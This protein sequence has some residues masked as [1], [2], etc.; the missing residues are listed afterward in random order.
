MAT[1][2]Q[3]LRITFAHRDGQISL[4]GVE[5][6]A[7]IPPASIGDP[8][9]R[10]QTGY[11]LEVRDASGRVL[12]HR[13]LHD[14]VR[15]DVEAFSPDAGP[16]ISRVPLREPAGRFTVLVPDL[17]DAQTFA[18]NGPAHPDRPDEPAQELLRIAVD[19][20]RRAKPPSGPPISTRP[21]G[22]RG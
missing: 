12:H 9:Q 16:S 20:L 15:R 19:A 22:T 6:V 14:P 11:W 3:T 10:G 4:E 17:P 5:R 8:P 18:L 13:A 21:P 2:P 1:P 7:M